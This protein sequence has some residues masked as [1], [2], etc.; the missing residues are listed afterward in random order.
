MQLHIYRVLTVVLGMGFSFLP[1]LA[2]QQQS[3]KPP[4]I[5]LFLS[6]DQ[7]WMDVGYQGSEIKTANIDR[8]AAAGVRFNQ[9]YAQPVCTPSRSALL[10]G[11]YPIRQGLQVMVVRP[12]A[13][14]GLPLEERTLAQALKEV[15]YRTAIVGKWHLG[16]HQRA[17]L[18][19]KRGFDHQYGHYNG[20]LNYFTHMR[21][22]GLDWHRDDKP[23]K[24][25]G[26]TTNLITREAVRIVESHNPAQPLFLYVPFNAPHAKL[27]AP[28]EYIDRYRH[29]KNKDRRIYA[30]MVHCMDDAIGNILDAFKK[31]G[32]SKNTLVYFSSDNGGADYPGGGAENGPLRGAKGS[33]YEGGV[34]V[35]AV[36]VWPGKIKPG[37]IVNEP[38]HIVDMYPT[39]LKLAGAG[40]D[41]PLPLD[42][43]DI[44]PTIVQGKPSPH[45]EILYNIDTRGGAIR[46][47]DWKL[48]QYYKTTGDQTN[49]ELFNLAKDPSEKVNLADKYPQKVKELI[50][51]LDRY[52]KAAVPPKGSYEM[53]K[54]PNFKSPKVWGET[55]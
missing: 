27:V 43:K 40:L 2:Q 1:A 12:W 7:G 18:P 4:H 51:R 52:A 47:G 16:H 13:D 37:T 6:D 24:E 26:Y 9:F 11:R 20:A 38:L 21:D 33:L 23:L 48:V 22:E 35:P 36:M 14:Y 42:G 50:V 54:P 17:Y 41:Q 25:E 44:W 53:D 19:T 8:L 49:T 39:L 55:D 28:Q 5:L 15:G 30:A 34:R 31:R 32:M 10:T 29:I 46:R 3:T 45:D